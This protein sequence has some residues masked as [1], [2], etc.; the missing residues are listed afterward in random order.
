M[1]VD[2]GLL[3]PTLKIRR[4]MAEQRFRDAIEALY[5]E[6]VGTH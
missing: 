4:R 1:T 2:G 5:Q 3:T 6:P